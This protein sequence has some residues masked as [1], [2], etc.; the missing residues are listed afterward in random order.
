MPNDYIFSF[1]TRH[2]AKK[3]SNRLSNMSGWV[4]FQGAFSRFLALA[5]ELIRGQGLFEE[6]LFDDPREL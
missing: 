2:S 4:L 3:G 6:N 5:R 1:E